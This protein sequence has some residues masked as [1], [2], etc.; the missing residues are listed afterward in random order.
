MIDLRKLRM[1][2]ALGRLG[3]IAAVADEMHLTPSGISMQLAALERELALTLTERRGRRLALTPAGLTLA[4]HGRDVIAR[5]SLAETDVEA[6]RR[7]AAGTY[8]L[9][10]FP[11]AAR[12]FV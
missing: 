7:G 2:E 10:A 6:L 5:L 8:R 9:A 11:S 3:T 1:L 12:T 4:A